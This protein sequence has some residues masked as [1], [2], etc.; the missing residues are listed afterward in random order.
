MMLAAAPEARAADPEPAAGTRIELNKIVPRDG[1]GC[2]LYVAFDNIAPAY[3][4]LRLDLVLFGTDGVILRRIAVDAAPLR[5]GKRSV[6][7][8]EIDDLPCERLGEVLL[9]DV[10]ACRD[11]GGES[12]DA[13]LARIAVGSRVP[14]VDLVR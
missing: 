13:C 1:G 11:E 8:F 12:T 14:S 5:R 4:L 9:N 6:K 7:L 10:L 2:R 3:A